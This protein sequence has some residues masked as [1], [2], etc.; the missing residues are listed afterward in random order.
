MGREDLERGRVESATTVGSGQTDVERRNMELMQTLDDAWNAQDLAIAA[1]KLTV[2][3][4]QEMRRPER[5]AVVARL[6]D[7]HVQDW[8]FTT[9]KQG[10]DDT[11]V[12]FRKSV[13]S[14]V[15]EVH[16]VIPLQ[17]G[18][19]DRNQIGVL[20]AHKAT[21][22]E[23]WVY[24]VHFAAGD[25]AAAATAR[26]EAAKR[27]VQSIQA[28]AADKK[29]PFVLAGD[30]NA[31]SEEVVGDVLRKSDL[32]KYTRNVADLVVNNGCKTFNG[33]AGSAGLQACYGGVASHID[34]VWVVK[35][36]MQVLRYQVTATVQTS[37]SSDHNPLTTILKMP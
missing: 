9:L 7:H 28:E 6:G 18:L 15:R 11:L 8:G 37:R 29:Q 31:T 1:Q 23:V 34:Q 22:R 5:D 36:G 32:M 33:R 24:S 35:A 2:V 3:A 19:D 14:K 4:I 30:F 27:T 20:L 26:A 13:W 10:A 21:G 12:L 17:P 16:F 25:S